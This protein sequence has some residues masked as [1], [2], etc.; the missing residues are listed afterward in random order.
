MLNNQ[1]VLEQQLVT[2]KHLQVCSC[3]M[4]FLTRCLGLHHLSIALALGQLVTNTENNVRNYEEE[5]EEKEGI[6]TKQAKYKLTKSNI[7][8]YSYSQLVTPFTISERYLCNCEGNNNSTTCS[9]YIKH[10]R[11]TVDRDTIYNPILTVL[12]LVKYVQ[13][14]QVVFM[15]LG[16]IAR[17]HNLIN[18]IYHPIFSQ[19]T[20]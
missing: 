20:F 12:V 6:D 13:L 15:L 11:F 3:H 19:T 8:G 17:P 9:F 4:E 18:S 14:V 10:P 7:S 1:D 16:L 2:S 5:E